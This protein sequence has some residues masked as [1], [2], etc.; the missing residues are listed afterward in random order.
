[1]P[2]LNTLVPE[3]V[4]HGADITIQAGV[5]GGLAAMVTLGEVYE[6]DYDE[7]DNLQKLPILGSRRTGVRRGRYAVTGSL[8]AYWLNSEVASMVGGLANVTTAGSA[9]V[10]Y[11]SA[12]TFVRFNIVIQGLSTSPTTTLVNVVFEKDALKIAE[13]NLTDQTINF[14]AEDILGQ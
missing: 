4:A 14:V 5:G 13:A 8:K 2:S 7:D 9:S 10:V 11:H 6:M 1:M 3:N 12:R